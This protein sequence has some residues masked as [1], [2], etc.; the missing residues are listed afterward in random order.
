MR[1]L[2]HAARIEEAYADTVKSAQFQR[3]AETVREA[4]VHAVR[5]VHPGVHFEIPDHQIESCAEFLSNFEKVFT[6]NYDLQLYW[7][8]LRASRNHTDG[9]GLGPEASG[10]RTFNEAAFCST[11]YLH[12]ALHLFED[13]SGDTKKR[14]LTS[15][16][17]IDDIANTIRISRT[18]PLFVAEGTTVQKIRK[19]N[20]V[21]YL[22]NCYQTLKGITGHLFVFGHSASDNDIHIYD[23]IFSSRELKKLF[24]CVH[25]PAKD[26]SLLREKLARFAERRRDVS[27]HYV[28]S[29]TAKV[30]G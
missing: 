6:L 12:G 23:A 13:K 29:A 15:S 17:I 16:T 1:A 27:I 14:V 25:N 30:W 4:L 21:A 26:W 8:I 9:F 7:V 3:D 19:I 18:L 24:F 28:D 10:F 2:E 20:S 22:R 5:A 11:Y